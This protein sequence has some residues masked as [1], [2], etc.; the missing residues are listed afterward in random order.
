M[1]LQAD[2]NW[3]KSEVDKIN[4]PLLIDLFKRLL[5]YRDQKV[6]SEMDQM[7]LDAEEDVLNGNVISHEELGK[8]MESWRNGH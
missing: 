3:I 7:I 5:Q 6:Q 8:R 2:K 1:N 4:D